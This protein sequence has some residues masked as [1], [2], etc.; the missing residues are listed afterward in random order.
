[1]LFQVM[2]FSFAFGENVKSH[3]TGG[4]SPF[5]FNQVYR[6]NQTLHIDQRALDGL[7][8]V[9][10][11]PWISFGT[12]DL[13]RAWV[14]CVFVFFN[15]FM[16]RHSHNPLRALWGQTPDGAAGCVNLLSFFYSK[17]LVILILLIST[18]PSSSHKNT[19][20]QTLDL[21]LITKLFGSIRLLF[22]GRSM[23]VFTCDLGVY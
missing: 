9:T 19:I 21:W 4:T 8:Q 20:T 17:I 3:V 5:I 7:K 16:R 18:T 10:I 11:D 6:Y 14:P 13:D 1:M 2:I 22:L 15:F 23:P 12:F